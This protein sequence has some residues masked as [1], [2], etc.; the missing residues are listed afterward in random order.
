ML[1]RR[2]R[3]KANKSLRETAEV[4]SGEI[5]DHV[6]LA[7]IERGRRPATAD[8]I[9]AFCDYIGVGTEAF[10]EAA[11]DFHRSVWEP[12]CHP[13]EVVDQMVKVSSV[14]PVYDQ[15]ELSSA[16]RSA[17]NSMDIAS[18]VLTQCMG[19]LRCNKEWVRD[20][21]MAA[22]VVLML[23]GGAS[24]SRLVLEHP[25]EP[26]SGTKPYA[27]SQGWTDVPNVI[28]DPDWKDADCFEVGKVYEHRTGRLMRIVGEV[29][30]TGYFNPTLVG[31]EMGRGDLMPVG[32]DEDSAQNYREVPLSRWYKAWLD[33]NPNNEELGKKWHEAVL[34][35]EGDVE[36]SK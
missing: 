8:Q 7:E 29:E 23:E 18:D 21:E 3:I 27:E 28:S 26:M 11:Q 25:L 36:E 6:V 4:L 30:T 2:F 20:A 32:C 19:I 22:S 10:F 34:N 13:L 15:Q 33:A 14:V 31:E 24:F 17:I 9:H 5:E 35:E 12:N 16:L 1:F